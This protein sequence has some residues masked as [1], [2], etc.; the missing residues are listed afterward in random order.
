MDHLLKMP[1]HR[2]WKVA[3]ASVTGTS[4]RKT[5]Q[6]CQDHAGYLLMPKVSRDTIVAAVADGLGSAKHS[7]VGSKTA[8]E[9]AAETASRLIWQKR[10]RAISPPQMESVLNA[11]VLHARIALEE[12]A[13]AMSVP[14]E[15]LATTL[16]IMVHTQGMIATAH[17]GDGAAVVSTEHG[18]YRAMA[19]PQRGEYAN[20][21]TALT[22]R[23]ALQQCDIAIA[24]PRRPVQEIALTTDGLLNLSMD[25]A[26]MEPHPPFFQNMGN[27]LRA[28]DGRQ[29]PN[30]ELRDTL[31]SDII[32]RRTDDDI[33]LFLAVRSQMT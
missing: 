30:S 15:D 10:L 3:Q 7:A 11:S 4:H 29:H 28:H 23:R 9:A 32:T 21:T 1:H 27:W 26:T 17:V 20:E 8:T 16:L 22:S 24:R 6:P 33:T 13:H 12:K 31:A 19:K 25:M 2:L 5:G 18:E 14:L